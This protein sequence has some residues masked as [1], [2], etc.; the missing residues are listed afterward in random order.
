MQLGL[1]AVEVDPVVPFQRVG[2]EAVLA[3]HVVADLVHEV[4][5]AR[6]PRRLRERHLDG[7]ALQVEP[8]RVLRAGLQ[9]EDG[10]LGRDVAVKR[11]GGRPEAELAAAGA[12]RSDPLPGVLPAR[13]GRDDGAVGHLDAALPLARRA[14]GDVNGLGAPARLDAELPAN[15]APAAGDRPR[16]VVT[17]R[18]DHAVVAD[19]LDAVDG[20]AAADAGGRMHRAG[21]LDLRAHRRIFHAEVQL[22]PVARHAVYAP[23]AERLPQRLAREPL[24]PAAHQPA[25]V[26]A[27]D[28]VV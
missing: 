5:Y 16:A 25:A 11:R 14:A 8:Q 17:V 1:V 20:V 23:L 22:D 10:R 26:H 24:G 2:V 13:L 6:S 27:R 21:R 15:A 7:L 4:H 12:Y 9:L 3:P 28:A 18:G 19:Q